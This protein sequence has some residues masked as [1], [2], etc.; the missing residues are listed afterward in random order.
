ME[1]QTTHRVR[2]D[3]NSETEVTTTLLNGLE[4]VLGRNEL[5]N[6]PPLYDH[7]DPDALNKLFSHVQESDRMRGV[8]YFDFAD[9]RVAIHA[10]GDIVFFTPERSTTDLIESCETTRSRRS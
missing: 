4:E 3:W 6:H 7:V 1:S 8:V 9:Y 5:M 2:H 10:T